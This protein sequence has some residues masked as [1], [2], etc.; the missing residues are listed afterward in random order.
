MA[1][2]LWVI[3]GFTTATVIH[4]IVYTWREIVAGRTLNARTPT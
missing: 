2:V 1:P 4:R 3:A